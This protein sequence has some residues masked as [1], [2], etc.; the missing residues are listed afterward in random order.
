MQGQFDYS[1]DYSMTSPTITIVDH[2]GKEVK[3]N[4]FNKNGQFDMLGIEP[5]KVDSRLYNYS[6]HSWTLY[7]LYKR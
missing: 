2:N 1:K 4:S 5:S 6:R 7:Y 3:T